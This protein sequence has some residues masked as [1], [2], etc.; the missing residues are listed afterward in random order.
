VEIAAGEVG[1]GA[2]NPVYQISLPAHRHC[3]AWPVV[4]HYDVLT[5]TCYRNRYGNTGFGTF[6]RHPHR[7][8]GPG[9]LT[10]HSLL[11]GVF[12]CST[13]RTP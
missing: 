4:A 2:R 5:V 13:R 9:Y 6:L 8:S 12:L 7:V 3:I 1:S 11:W 10:P